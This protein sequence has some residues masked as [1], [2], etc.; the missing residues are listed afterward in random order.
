MKT[1]EVI[2]IGGRQAVT[3]PD[4]FR[5]TD[6]TV[7]IRKEG[8]TVILEP[9][10]PDSWPASF[11]EDIRIN[12]PAFARPPQGETPLAPSFELP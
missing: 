10:K 8:K 7:S 4:E 9:L 3:L 5:F 6:A 1:A 11:F 2:S 12:D